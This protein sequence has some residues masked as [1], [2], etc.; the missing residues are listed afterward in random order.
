[1]GKGKKPVEG[2]VVEL[3]D[4]GEMRVVE[5]KEPAGLKENRE[6]DMEYYKKVF[7]SMADTTCTECNM[8]IYGYSKGWRG[9]R[10]CRGCH[11]R[12]KQSYS[13]DF[14]AYIDEV[15]SSGC[16]FCRKKE[17]RFHLDHKNMFSKTD[18][19]CDM[20]ERGCDEAKIR[21]EI[22]KCQLLCIAC[23]EIVTRYEQKAGF[24]ASKKAL[25]KMERRGD[26]GYMERRQQLYDKYEAVMREIYLL[27]GGMV[28]IL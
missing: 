18:S 24:H 7:H 10:V 15:Y 28:G 11:N 3:L 26:S 25:N 19:V 8:G 5:L 22:D 1:M 4:D 27:V 6:Y 14:L 23:H 2:I 21:E 9:R 16:T 13:S 20:I 17:G 12:L